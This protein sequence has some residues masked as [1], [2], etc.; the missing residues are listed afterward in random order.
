MMVPLWHVA[1][2]GLILFA[3]Y[4]AL[5]VIALRKQERTHAKQLARVRAQRNRWR[6]KAHSWADAAPVDAVRSEFDAIM[7][8]Q[9]VADGGE[10]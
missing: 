8:R 1:V 5:L 3:A 2:F 6:R 9:F 10:G 4:A 7:H